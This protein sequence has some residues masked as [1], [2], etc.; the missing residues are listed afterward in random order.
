MGFPELPPSMLAC[1]LLKFHEPYAIHHIPVPSRLDP[2]D[3][4][5]KVAVTAF[6][7]TD[8]MVSANLMKDTQLPIT[9]SHEGCGTVVAVGSSVHSFH[10]GDRVLAGIP[11]N[12]CGTC[13]DCTSP[14]EQYCENRTG[15][16]GMQVDGAFAEYLVADSRNGCQLP[17]NLDFVNAA[18]LACAGITAWRGLLEAELSKGQVLGIVGSGGGLG[19]LL[20]EF[21]KAQ[22]LIVVGVDVRDEGLQLSQEA[23][24]SL[25]LDAREGTE[26]VT[27][28][29]MEFTGGVRAAATINLSEAKTAA[30]LACSITAKHGR[31][32]Q[33]AQPNEICIPYREIIF[34]DIHVSGS[35]TS[36][37]KQMQDMVEF[38]AKH[39]ILVKTNVYHG[40][41]NIPML[42]ADFHGGKMKGKGVV[43]VDATQL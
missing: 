18:P 9:A 31:M 30:G 38:V 43:V 19:H 34:R 12:R 33:I 21:A 20:I 16:I 22:G 7:H 40:L 4:L 1:Q 17:D 15:G 11:R 26:A 10:V 2:Y 41:N 6:C 13:A 27:R 29:I 35:L 3:I 28:K 37:R 23:G 5:I 24:A 39:R 42:V 32:I 14:Q 25:V 8:A 36:S